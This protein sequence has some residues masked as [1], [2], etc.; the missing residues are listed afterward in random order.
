MKINIKIMEIEKV[1]KNNRLTMA[2]LGISAKEFKN[3]LVTFEQILLEEQLKINKKRKIGGGANGMIKN[4]K[5]KLFFILFY[6]KTYP[7]FD[8][9]G[10]V[11]GSSKT[12]THRWFHD[13]LPL[14]EKTLG[15]NVVLPKR[16]ISTPEEFFKSFPEVKE[17]MI[18]GVERPTIRSKKNPAPLL[19]IKV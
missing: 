10:Y 11:F 4:P 8:I 6:L 1:L 7:T 13:I 18:D 14:L 19:M 17:V 16:Q 12:S 9:A 5:N 2:L 3:L 15:R